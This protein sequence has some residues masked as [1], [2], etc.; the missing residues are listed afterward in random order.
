[1]IIHNTF[2]VGSV[3]TVYDIIEQ[4]SCDCSEH[5]MLFNILARSIGIPSRRVTGYAYD[6]QSQSFGWHDWNEVVVDGYWLPVDPTWNWNSVVGHI[7]QEEGLNPF[8]NNIKFKL[9]LIEFEN[10]EEQFF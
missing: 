8:F 1:M 6:P 9:V 10:G 3:T 7:K 2:V 5:A 4:N